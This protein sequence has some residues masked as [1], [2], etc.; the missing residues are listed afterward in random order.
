MLTRTAVQ[1]VQRRRK[2]ARDALKNEEYLE[3]FEVRPCLV[4]RSSKDA[5]RAALVTAPGPRLVVGP[6]V[7]QT[8]L[9]RIS[10]GQATV[11]DYE[12]RLAR[13]A[14]FLSMNCLSSDTFEELEEGALLY[15]NELFLEGGSLGDGTKLWAAL[16]WRHPEM[17]ANGVVR[18]PRLQQALQGWSKGSPPNQRDPMSWLEACGLAAE[19]VRTDAWMAA[20]AL[21]VMYDCYLRPGEAFDLRVADAARP[22]REGGRATQQWALTVRARDLGRPSKTGAVDDTGVID[23]PERRFLGVLLEAM[24]AQRAPDELLFASLDA[25][26]YN[27]CFKKACAVLGVRLVPYQ[28]RHGGASG[29]RA[30]GTRTLEQIR[31]RGRWQSENSTRR[32]EKAGKLQGR[33]ARMR[34]ERLQHLSKMAGDIFGIM[35]LTVPARRIRFGL[36]AEPLG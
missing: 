32:Y 19:L 10:V 7:E 17:S 30:D 9:E 25:K 29:D 26:S 1:E 8:L 15:M 21:L 20:A 35:S 23:H 24:T 16:R 22:V 11:A 31:K 34:P 5:I 14:D 28:A 18:L 3:R 33:L 6:A 2:A 36:A 13:L 12:N 27:L 4:G